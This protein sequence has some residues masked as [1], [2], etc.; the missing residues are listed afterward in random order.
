MSEDE[1]IVDTDEKA[2][3]LIPSTKPGGRALMTVKEA[4]AAASG[5]GLNL[6]RGKFLKQQ[7]QLGQFIE[8]IGAVA[9][10]RGMYLLTTEQSMLAAEKAMSLIDDAPDSETKLSLI[11]AH[12]GYLELMQKSAAGLAKAS[13]IVTLKNV[14]GPPPPP[15]PGVIVN[16]NSVI[17][18]QQTNQIE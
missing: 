12:Q 15:P 7:Q 1:S 10:S 4:D 6:I 8:E 5:L 16:T 9:V 3:R 17:M 11:K 13:E 18:T 2:K 14:N